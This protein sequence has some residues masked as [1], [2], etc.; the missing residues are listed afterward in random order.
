MEMVIQI[1][2]DMGRII[3]I[4]HVEVTKRIGVGNGG[5][6][7]RIGVFLGEGGVGEGGQ[8]ST[9]KFIIFFLCDIR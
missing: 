3:D 2:Y 6:R 5:A 9:P 7:D 1:R 8:H 4:D